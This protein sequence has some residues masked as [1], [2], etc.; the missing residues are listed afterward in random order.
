[1]LAYLT[2]YLCVFSQLDPQMASLPSSLSSLC[3]DYQD[4]VCNNFVFYYLNSY[5]LSFALL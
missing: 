5:D 3:D 2:V 4:G 1:M